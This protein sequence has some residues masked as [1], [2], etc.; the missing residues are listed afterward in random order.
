[1][2]F[3]QILLCNSNN[4]IQKYLFICCQ[5]IRSKY[6]YI[7]PII[8]FLHIGEQF[9]VLL[10][11]TNNSFQHDS[12]ACSQWHK[13]F[14]ISLHTVK[15]S[16]SSIW[17]CDGTL[18]ST[19]FLGQSR[20]GSNDNEGVLNTSQILGTEPSLLECL[21]SYIEHSLGRSYEENDLSIWFC[22]YLSRP[23]S[24]AFIVN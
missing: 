17:S 10:F 12:F 24:F 20:L 4:S 7:I 23:K 19:I 16:N 14:N 2:T 1:M 3:L 18:I 6:C 15:W 8:Q 5:S 11:N 13:Q 21:V 22:L 9:Q